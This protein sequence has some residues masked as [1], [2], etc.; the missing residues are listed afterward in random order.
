MKW[1][2]DWT[3]V[4]EP[5]RVLFEV[6]HPPEA[7]TIEG[8]EGALALLEI[9]P[10][11][12]LAI[13]GTRAPSL[14]AE[15]IVQAA[16]DELRGTGLVIV[17]GLARGVDATA[18]DSAIDA[19]LSTIAILGAGIDV[20]YPRE[21][22]DLRTRI[23]AS[24]GLVVTEFPDGAEPRAGCFI[25]RN[26]L[27]AGWTRAT[28]VVE[29]SHRSGALNTA[30]WARELDRTCLATPCFPGDPAYAGNQVLLDRDHALPFWG[31]HSLGAVWLELAQLSSQPLVHQH[32]SPASDLET[33]LSWIQRATR[34]KGG[35]RIQELFS[36]S[37]EVGWNSERLLE[38]LKAALTQRRAS[39]SEG[40]I[41]TI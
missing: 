19:G 34:E 38:A 15:P 30:R 3:R 35:A 14:R 16:L 25:R 1:R 41:V 4:P 5:L 9:L 28:W 27:I 40:V 11:R 23:I 6:P 29:A 24:G 39:E 7:L 22:L 32:R 18:H 36:L 12:G 20:P 2:I 8:Q 10:D 13:V 17:S 21:N 26:R 31:A 33:F 37:E